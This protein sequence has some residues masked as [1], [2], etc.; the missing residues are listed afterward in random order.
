MAVDARRL[1]G[2]RLGDILMRYV[3]M[4]YL[5]LIGCAAPP[6]GALNAYC[7]R[8]CYVTF[9]P[10]TGNSPAGAFTPTF[11]DVAGTGTRTLTT[12]ETVSP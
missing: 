3:V 2:V 5:L 7:L 9:S 11:G 12:S 1:R 6:T 8:S 10:M 4:F